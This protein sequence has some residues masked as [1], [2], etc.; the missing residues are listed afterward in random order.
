MK[1]KNI[2]GLAISL[3]ACTFL[4]VTGATTIS[5]VTIEKEIEQEHTI[6]FSDIKESDWY[7]DDV[8]YVQKNGL[9]SGK[10]E[11]EFCPHAPVTRQEIADIRGISSDYAVNR[12]VEFG[13]IQECGRQD[14]PGRAI[15]GRDS[16]ET[17]LVVKRARVI[18][19]KADG[20]PV[21]TV[22]R[23]GKGKVVYVNFA[24]ELDAIN[25]GNCFSGA[26][27]S[28]HYLVYGTAARE[29]GVAHR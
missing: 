10:S 28:P 15:R 2:V 8:K 7:Y 20:T 11:T 12:L 25:S 23:L 26:D 3:L 6:V 24:I 18:A 9:M 16:A 4:I 14:A 1:K 5:G 19:A 17:E 27:I 21:V 13:L 29:A 22:N